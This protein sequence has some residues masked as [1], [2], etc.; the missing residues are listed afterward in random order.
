MM[1]RIV[2][3]LLLFAAILLPLSAQQ[4]PA[5]VLAYFDDDFELQIF[6][7]NGFDVNFFIGMG[8]SPGDRVVTGNTSAEIRLDP[9]GSI[10]RIAPNTDF[11]VEALQGRDS[12]QATDMRLQRGRV[13][14]IAARLTGNDER[15]NVRTPTAVA[16]VRGTDF[17]V[18]VVPEATL[19]D[20]EEVPAEDGAP[21]EEGAPNEPT[22]P[23]DAPPPSEEL[24]VFEGEVLFEAVESG[25]Q[26]VVLAGQRADVFAATFVPQV[27][28]AAE[29]MQRSQGL[30]FIELNPT[31]VP[32]Q[33]VPE[34]EVV[35]VEPEPEPEPP[36]EAP[37]TEDGLG[38]RL[39]GRLASI[40]GLQVGSITINGETFAQ[41]VF[42]PRV[43][44][45]RLD[46]ALYLPITY[47]SNIFDPGDWYRPEGND[48]WSFG[49]DQD[50]NGDPLGALQDV[51]TD[52]ALK[53][54]SL[55]YGEREDPF[56]L[57]V[58]NLN[59]FTIGQG[60]LMRNYAND[61]DFPV[62][63][64]VGFNVGFDREKWGLEALVNDLARPEIYGGRLFF[65][66]AAPAINAAVGLSAVTD[67]VPGRGIS[68]VDASG[69]PLPTATVATLESASNADPLFLNVGADLELP[70]IDRERL[71]L[72][73]FAEAGGLIPYLR[74]ETTV[75]SQT[76]A[77][78]LKTSALVD[79]SSGNLKNFG[80]TAGVRGALLALDYRL[81][82]RSFDGIFR[83]AFYGP[84]YDRLRG[85]IA[86]DTVAYL[87][88]TENERYQVTTLGVAGEAGASIF[89]LL[90]LSAG[91]F[92]PW[93]V[94]ESGSW[95]GSDQ[96]ELVVSVTAN[97]GL[98]PFGIETG[99]QYRRTHFAA[100]V[101]GWGEYA[102]ATLFD[103]NTT[104]DGFVMYPFND[105]VSIEARVSTAVV[106]NASG[107]IVYDDNG[108]PEIAPTVA[109]QT[110]LGF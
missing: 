32:G 102:D 97:E 19:A 105:V 44:F 61:V 37:E 23:A 109:I 2:T 9:N 65:R 11:T 53:I 49:S 5:A 27:M 51:A 42:Q 15:Y 41:A 3:V 75:G 78:G 50:W 13:R 87:A 95:R 43:S 33:V 83:P 92:W 100:T 17:G 80:W 14:M 36:Q 101:A 99:L 55:E 54:R 79:F 60:L 30:E 18:N 84:N 1:K 77:A 57:K 6:D 62:V 107:E 24:F 74:S 98:I 88:D 10:I 25:E 93:E 82:F 63:R 7:E 81:E 35:S 96:D 48:E 39:F 22:P 70:V 104:L 31:D 46:L 90:D 16:G 12:A 108:N 29:I 8:L 47:R 58:G 72:I 71:S 38:D 76:I 52:L 34:P 20:E 68:T 64:R 59:N 94:T 21:G 67:I 66:P 85:Q 4:E 110:R 69:N 91:Y 73:G 40:T 56:F 28:S 26:I 106:R 89:G 86:A 45:G 103:A